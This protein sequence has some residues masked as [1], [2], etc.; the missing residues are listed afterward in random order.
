[1]KNIVAE[2]FRKA[3]EKI[4]FEEHAT[5]NYEKIVYS[6]I[7]FLSIAESGAMGCPGELLVATKREQSV[8]WYCFNMMVDSFDELCSFYPP[9]KT[10][11]CGIFGKASGIQDG[12][13]HV[14][15]GCGNHLLVRDDYIDAFELAVKFVKPKHPGEVYACWRGIAQMLLSGEKKKSFSIGGITIEFAVGPSIESEANVDEMEIEQLEEYLAKLE[16]QLDELEADE[17]ED[18][19]SDE[20]EEWEDQ[21]EELR[22]LIDEVQERLEELQG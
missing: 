12:W 18:D 15:L 2:H 10:F 14:D 6:D 4:S 1:M 19:D 13:N 5:N 11:N 16:E 8:K 20:Y 22:N 7:V 21:C 17:P 3:G 9:L